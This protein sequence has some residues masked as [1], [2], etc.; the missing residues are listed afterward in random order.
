MRGVL[1]SRA[2]A[3]VRCARGGRACEYYVYVASGALQGAHRGSITSHLMNHDRVSF[4]R[5]ADWLAGWPGVGGDWSGTWSAGSREVPRQNQVPRGNS[6]RILGR[7][8]GMDVS[9][10]HRDE[11]GAVYGPFFLPISPPP[12][13]FFI[14]SVSQSSLTLHELGACCG[15]NSSEGGLVSCA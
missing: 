7:R 10:G 5:R 8:D 6:V 1:A 2:A 4:T 3:T 9:R 12:S 14:L 15:Q 13:P 11:L